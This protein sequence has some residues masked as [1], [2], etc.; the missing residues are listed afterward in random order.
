MSVLAMS[1]PTKDTHLGIPAVHSHV[2]GSLFKGHIK[3]KPVPET[4]AR[5]KKIK[6]LQKDNFSETNSRILTL[7]K[8]TIY[9]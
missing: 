6:R 4:Q 5:K 9:V 3:L 2:Q 7:L 8:V 1:M